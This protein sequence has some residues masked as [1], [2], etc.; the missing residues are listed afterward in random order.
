[1]NFDV[2]I[3]K[4][5]EVK[6]KSELKSWFE[7]DKLYV[8]E[9]VKHK[10]NQLDEPE[11]LSQQWIDENIVYADVKGNTEAFLNERSVRNLLVPKQELPLIPKFVTEW[12]ESEGKRSSW[13]NWF[14]KWGRDE[15]RSDLET[16]T[17]GWMQDYN[18][19]KFVDMFRFGYEVEK[20]PLYYAK[21]KGWEL[22]TTTIV[23][24]NYRHIVERPILS[25][26]YVGLK[27]GVDSFKTKMTKEEWNKVGI[28]DTNA[29]F[30]VVS[31]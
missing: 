22:A 6:N 31:E 4:E 27:E 21:I 15:R 26:L 17:I 10:I 30:E 8:G 16:K 18:E 23:F 19:E 28:N 11:V 25:K 24:W 14:Y 9:Y 1:M 7:D 2:L 5:T 29:D 3:G 13:W 12:Y 20:E